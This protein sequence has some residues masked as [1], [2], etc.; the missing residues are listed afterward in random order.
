MSVSAALKTPTN[1]YFPMNTLKI[2]DVPNHRVS[3][4]IHL[5]FVERRWLAS[6]LAIAG[7][8][9]IISAPALAQRDYEVVK[10]RER[11]ATLSSAAVINI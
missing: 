8:A 11:S 7:W 5:M 4:R 3:V 6:L 2:C 1:R 9:L 10:P